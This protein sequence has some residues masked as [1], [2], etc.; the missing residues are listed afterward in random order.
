MNLNEKI[1]I[2]LLRSSGAVMLMAL[3]AVVMPYEW[4]NYFRDGSAVGVIQERIAAAG[5]AV[6][7]DAGRGI[8]TASAE[9]D[10]IQPRL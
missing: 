9:I 3:G 5:G 6:V 7:I 1:L 10:A 2:W 8:E 4:M